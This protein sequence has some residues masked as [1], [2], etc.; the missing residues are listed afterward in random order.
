MCTI[1]S[2][3]Y[4][5]NFNSISE[6]LCEAE[7]SAISVWCFK[8]NFCI[9]LKLVFVVFACHKSHNFWSN[10]LMCKI[11]F[12]KSGNY[13]V[14]NKGDL[15]QRV[16]IRTVNVMAYLDQ[17]FGLRWPIFSPTLFFPIIIKAIKLK[18]FYCR[19]L[20]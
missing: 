10:F 1:K 5:M 15:D 20:V 14:G 11:L 18:F 7:N 13:V 19:K 4:C 16:E 12:R 8:R 3:F 9:N 2:Q 17:C 6:R